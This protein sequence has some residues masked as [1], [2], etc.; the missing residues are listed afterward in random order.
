MTPFDTADIVK[1]NVPLSVGG[2]NA[3][4]VG[5]Q[6]TLDGKEHFAVCLGKWDEVEVPLVR[7]HSECMTG[8]LFGSLRCDCGPQLEE[9][10]QRIEEHGGIIVYLRQ[11]GRGIGLFNKLLAY[12][13]QDKGLDTFE[14]NERLGL[15]RDG[16]SFDVAADMLRR[17]NVRRIKL[18][19]NNPRKAMQLN[20]QGIEVV[21]TLPTSTFRSPYNIRYLRSKLETE[22]HSLN[23]G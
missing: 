1:V 20:E 8:D 11:E 16:R 14:A 22:R 23:L 9:S 19:S 3:T 10:I 4:F 6:K 2:L 5:F 17:M 21:E 18:L 12:T 13:W 15:D 7:I